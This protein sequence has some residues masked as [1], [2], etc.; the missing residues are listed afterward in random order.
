MNRLR[1]IAPAIAVALVWLMLVAA[2]PPASAFQSDD[3]AADSVGAGLQS[4]TDTLRGVRLASDPVSSPTDRS[5]EPRGA[6]ARA[7]QFEPVGFQDDETDAERAAR[8]QAE[9]EAAAR[10]AESEAFGEA[11]VDLYDWIEAHQPAFTVWPAFETQVVNLASFLWIVDQG[12]QEQS[13][14]AE[15]D[16]IQ[17]MVTATP[18]ESY[19]FFEER[20]TNGTHSVTCEGRGAEYTDGAR[21]PSCSRRYE[22]SSSVTGLVDLTVAI[23]FEISVFSSLD[24]SV[25]NFVDG[26]AIQ[27]S[28]RSGELTQE[29]EVLEVLT[30]GLAGDGADIP[31]TEPRPPTVV[32]PGEAVDCSWL[33]DQLISVVGVSCHQ[34]NQAWELLQAGVAACADGIVGSISDTLDTLRELATTNPITTIR[35]AIADV[36]ELIDLAQNDPELF[37]QVIAEGAI[38]ITLEDWESWDNAQRT[39][40]VIKVICGRAL[41]FITGSALDRIFGI[42][43]RGD[44]N[45]GSGGNGD[46]N[47]DGGGNGDGNDDDGNDDDDGNNG[48]CSIA[49]FPAGTPVLMADGGY[50]DIEQIRP[51]DVVLSY[52]FESDVWEP[53]DVLN[54]WSLVD[55]E[56]AATLTLPD[57]S[58]A[59][60]TADHRFWVETTQEWTEIQDVTIGD[61]FLTPD[62]I[63]ELADVT[64]ADVG[65]WV[66]WELTVEHNHNFAIS[67]GT[68]D[69][70]VHNAPGDRDCED[71]D[72]NGEDN[73]YGL[74]EEDIE[75]L[76][77]YTGDGYD[78]LNEA[79][80]NGT[81]TPDQQAR[82]DAINAA[83]AK[84]DEFDGNELFRGTDL[85]DDVL[86]DLLET[87]QF[88]DDGFMSS[89]TYDG[90][91]E[92]FES[93][94][95]PT[96]IT[97]QDPPPGGRVIPDEYSTNPGE[98]EVV[99][100]P[101][102]EFTVVGEPQL[103]DGVWHITL[104]A[105]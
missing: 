82:V 99:F 11:V 49:S 28:V 94:D 31:A 65:T 71:D 48:G 18:T 97:I 42:L 20:T 86:D 102:T 103:I 50:V 14:T 105:S 67:T 15:S 79:L 29:L 6:V 36:N 83:L 98:Y 87:G 104:T 52:N 60:A 64:L 77:N 5:F 8:E 80:R 61:E 40:E 7:L 33:V 19:W 35:D 47:N 46:G 4:A 12:W 81:L 62:G 69:V 90:V 95:N 26:E 75:A 85:P 92:G 10:A 25:S 45:N 59:I 32:N 16:D 9:A 30:F 91:A 55:H 96:R 63:V 34:A 66:V 51:G 73:E 100:P 22:H 3:G 21:N 17:V 39:E 37:A 13:F 1:S 23:G 89:S 38:G 78:D 27:T 41:E 68:T 76:A 56:P 74:T 57:A 88:R 58:Q 24:D 44:G 70:L 53:R 54:Q 93:G 2:A 101:G 72:G 43:N 84:L